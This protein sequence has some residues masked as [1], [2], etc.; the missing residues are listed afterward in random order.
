VHTDDRTLRVDA[1]QYDAGDGPC[2]HAARTG[3]VVLVDASDAN[4]RWPRFASAAAD[5]GIHS[6][7]AAPLSAGDQPLGSFNLY[8]R[9]RSA[10]DTLD[11]DILNLLTATVSRTIGDFA[12]FRTARDVAESIQRA[13]STRAPIEQAKGMLMAIHGITAEEAFDRLRTESQHTNIPLR[14][15]ATTLIDKLG[16][17]APTATTRSDLHDRR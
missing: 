10:F 6:F 3:T 2:L 5:E 14:V 12:R 17:T 9:T 7:L 4:Q 8:G 1:E 11:A 13:L 15:V 16:A